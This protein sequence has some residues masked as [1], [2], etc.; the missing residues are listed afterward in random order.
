[1]TLV[2]AVRI[3]SEGNKHPLAVV[4]GASEN[5]ATAQDFSK[6]LWIALWFHFA[7]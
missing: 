3:D 7:A 2:A 6:G 1:L 4:E 5:A